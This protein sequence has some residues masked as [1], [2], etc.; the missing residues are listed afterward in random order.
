MKTIEM[1]YRV[2]CRYCRQA[3][4]LMEELRRSNEKYEKIEIRFL[5]TERDRELLAGRKFTYVPCFYID[6]EMVMEGVPTKEKIEAVFIQALQDTESR[7]RRDRTC[8]KLLREEIMLALGCTEPGTIAYAAACAKEILGDIPEYME[9]WVSGNILKN[10]KSVIIPN[11]GNLKGVAEAA[12]CGI[13]GGNPKRKLEVLNTLT[14]NDAD[15]VRKLVREEST[16]SIH[17]AEVEEPLYV[18]IDLRKGEHTALVEIQ[19]SHIHI[20]KVQKDGRDITKQYQRR[21]CVGSTQTNEDDLKLK[22]IYDFAGETSTAELKDILDMQ[23]ACNRK[24]AEEGMKND[25]GAKVGKNLLRLYKEEDAAVLAAYA[26][27]GSDARM[28]GSV[29]PVVANCGSGNQGITIAVPISIYAEKKDKSR[30]ALHRAMIFANLISIY[31][32]RGI[33]KLSAYCGAVNAGCAA[34]CGIAYLDQA[35]LA[36]MED[37]ITNTLATISG[38]LCDGAKP[39]CAAKIAMSVETGLLAYEMAKNQCRFMEGEGIVGKNADETIEAVGRIGKDG[40][41]ETDSKILEIMMGN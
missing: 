41:R 4:G 7:E 27:A 28:G 38:M 3:F 22:D 6:G 32:K 35:P 37:I 19:K 16:Y 26:A 33:G 29:L 20:T 8:N 30:E 5:D 13:V 17:L 10:V 25:Y 11:T 15:T 2:T 40:M 12:F 23:I 1:I 21:E 36:V 39:S 9:I 31:I 18:R 34:V 24:I 14:A